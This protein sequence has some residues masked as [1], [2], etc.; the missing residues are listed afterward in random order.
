MENFTWFLH[1]SKKCKNRR[2]CHEESNSAQGIKCRGCVLLATIYAGAKNTDEVLKMRKMIKSQEIKTTTGW[3]GIEVGDNIH[4]FFVV[5]DKSHPDSNEIYCKLREVI[6]Q[7]SL[8][9]YMPEKSFIVV[10]GSITKECLETSTSCHSEKL[11]I[12]FG[13]ARTS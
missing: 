6:C 12:A 7:A 5:G 8:L 9:G 10:T 2:N 3:S 13:L 1:D 11:A 4:K